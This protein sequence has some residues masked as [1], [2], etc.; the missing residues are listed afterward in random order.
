MLELT[1]RGS[2]YQRGRQIGEA[3][4]QHLRA[5]AAEGRSRPLH[6]WTIDRAEAAAGNVLFAM[7]RHAP[8]YV[9]EL[10]GLADAAYGP[11]WTHPHPSFTPN[12]QAVVYTADVSGH[13]QVYLAHLTRPGAPAATDALHP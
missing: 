1:V 7:L 13:A 11:Q 2:P 9:E 10:R 3:Y 12:G 4:A 8:H 6:G 5:E